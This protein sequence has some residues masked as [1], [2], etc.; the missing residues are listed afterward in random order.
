MLFIQSIHI[1][2][3]LC[4]PSVIAKYGLLIS[5]N[6]IWNTVMLLGKYSSVADEKAFHFCFATVY[7]FV[8][9]LSIKLKLFLS[10][11]S[12]V[13]I[14][15]ISILNI[16]I[17]KIMSKYSIQSLCLCARAIKL[18]PSLNKRIA[19]FAIRGAWW[20][21]SKVTDPKVRHFYDDANDN[22]E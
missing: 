20:V 8:T 14:R 10:R 12:A 11:T 1:V 18:P 6:V 9:V 3:S 21:R 17:S 19:H 5:L 22:C 15:S 2:C 13:L 16:C 7:F 4:R